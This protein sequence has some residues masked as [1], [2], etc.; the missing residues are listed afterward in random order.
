MSK[1]KHGA[2]D[3]PGGEVAD[4]GRVAEDTVGAFGRELQ[5]AAG[6]AER[7]NAAHRAAG[8]AMRDA[9]ARAV[10]AG[11]LLTEAKALVGHGGW[12]AWVGTNCVFSPRT[13]QAY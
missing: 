2:D 12:E 10:E 9:V 3:C 8:R 6:L 5:P 11:H 7:I 4:L 13:A 1:A